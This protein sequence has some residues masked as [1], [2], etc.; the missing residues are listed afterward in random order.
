V[1]R[2]VAIACCA[3]AASIAW[4]PAAAGATVPPGDPGP[5]TTVPSTAIPVN[6]APGAVAPDSGAAV[7]AP[8]AQPS[9][10]LIQIPQGC[11]Q[12]P[13]ASVVFV[14][15]VVATVPG[16]ARF[17]VRQI[18]AGEASAYMYGDLVD[19]AYDNETQ[20]LDIDGDYLVGAVPAG[21]PLALSSKV[22][23]AT[24]LFGGSATIGL[25]EKGTECPRVDDPVRTLYVDGTEIETDMLAAFASKKKEIAL[26]FV[27]PIAVV[28]AVV[29]ALVLVRWLFT[30]IIAAF[31]QAA[32]PEPPAVR[33]IVRDRR[34]GI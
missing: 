31:R 19:I 21:L 7:P 25:T 1:K 24:Q 27:K 17:R 11:Q 4:M 30:F 9:A 15:T 23:P 14:G 12:P 2:L 34:H 8:V 22:R 28:F 10:P 33:R 13:V 6:T 32:A 29:L 26:A 3:G 5:T 18:R 16:I 20:Y